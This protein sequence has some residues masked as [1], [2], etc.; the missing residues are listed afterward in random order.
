[1]GQNKTTGVI[2]YSQTYTDL[3]IITDKTK[4]AFEDVNVSYENR[5]ATTVVYAAIPVLDRAEGPVIQKFSLT[6]NPKKVSVSADLVMKT[7]YRTKT[8]AITEATKIVT[9]YKPANGAVSSYTENWDEL[10][11]TYNL[12]IEWTY[13]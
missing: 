10:T 7:D 5:N 2:T 13:K 3:D 12:S 11:G 9:S 1:M 6:D 4:V 8:E